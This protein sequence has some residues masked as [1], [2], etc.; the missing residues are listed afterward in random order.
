[1]EQE[2]KDNNNNGQNGRFFYVAGQWLPH[3][4][5]AQMACDLLLPHE[6][7]ILVNSECAK[8][9]SRM[10]KPYVAWFD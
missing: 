5:K 10:R 8:K 6:D 4:G 9:G 3:R 2:T 7:N 1:M